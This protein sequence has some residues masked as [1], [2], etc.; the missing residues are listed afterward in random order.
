MSRVA[1]CGVFD[2]PNYGDHLFPL[3]FRNELTKRGCEAEVVLFSPFEAE[4]SFVEDS[5]VYSLDDM[6]R[7][8]RDNPF[9]AIVVGG[10]EIIHWH[11]YRQKRSFQDE[12]FVDY[13]M[14]KVWA[15][16]SFM[17]MKHDVPLIWNAPGIP[18]DFDAD[19]ALA[20]FLLGNIDYLSVRNEFSAKVLEHC[21]LP[22]GGIHLVPDTG[23]AL[24]TIASED[25]LIRLRSEVVPDDERYII[26]HCNRFIDD[27]AR[28]AIV[29]ILRRL[30]EAYGCK[31]L[32]LP[33]AYTHGDDD[34]LRELREASNGE[35][36]MPEAPLSLKGIIAVLSG[37]EL[38]LGTSLH[39]TVTASVFGRKTVAFD[40]QK[41]KKTK[42]LY[43][44]LG[45]SEYYLTEVGQVED[46]VRKAFDCQR[47]VD[48]SEVERRLGIHFDAIVRLINHGEVENPN[49]PAQTTEFS[50]S[51][52]RHFAFAY[53]SQ[54]LR[55][56]VKELSEA[57]ETNERFVQIF[58]GRSEGL[59][60]Q[61]EDL[62]HRYEDLAHR[63]DKTLR[64]KVSRLRQRLSN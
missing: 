15:I 21:G 25:E 36:L 8:H 42:D 59:A 7:M 3:V 60:A 55:K 39:G 22:S 13:P 17:K 23:F 26:F 31:I 2:I 64:C 63:Y 29:G 33:L 41:T 46:A 19:E 18:Y 5:H 20:H 44:T 51:V 11:R 43:D 45:L 48:F 54:G 16:P 14:D 6:E 35:F 34:K 57:L 37:C 9:S 4:E 1:L 52:N 61:Y 28:D 38:Y 47:P 62:Q 27:D 10:G 49:P 53:E 58:K 40:Y 50:D 30:G 12:E 32:L 24:R 56:R